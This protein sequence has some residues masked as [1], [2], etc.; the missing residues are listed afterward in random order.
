MYILKKNNLKKNLWCFCTNGL[1]SKSLIDIKHS[2]NLLHFVPIIMKK[3]LNL[4]KWFILKRYFFVVVNNALK[5]NKYKIFL[6]NKGLG[7]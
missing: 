2:L 6:C 1:N 3:K 4:T 7:S 5:N